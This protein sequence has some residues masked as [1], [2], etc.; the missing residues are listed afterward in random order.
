MRLSPAARPPLVGL[1]RFS[2]D[3]PEEASDRIGF[4]APSLALVA[5]AS[6]VFASSGA[7]EAIASRTTLSQ[8][9]TPL[10]SMIVSVPSFAGLL[11]Q[12]TASLAVF[13]PTTLAETGSHI[14]PGRNH[15]PGSVPP[16]RFYALEALIHPLPAGLVS[17]RQRPWGCAL[18][19]HTRQQSRTS[20]R[21]PQ[22][23]CGW[24]EPPLQG[25]VP[26]RR[27]CFLPD[28]EPAGNS[29]P[30]GLFPP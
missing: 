2:E 12:T 27:P 29:A 14:L 8:P 15:L 3:L 26:C 23:S 30:H 17:Y 11:L 4:F 21:M 18:Q 28:S 22:P 6:E 9:F 10:Q 1:V 25:L 16:Q 20:F 5:L 19:G 7:R 24:P 13:P